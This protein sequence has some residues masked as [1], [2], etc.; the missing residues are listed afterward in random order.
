MYNT[1]IL[2]LSISAFIYFRGKVEGESL[3][4]VKVWRKKEERRKRKENEV[5]SIEESKIIRI[6]RPIVFLQKGK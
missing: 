1:F 2:N 6:F 3:V 5:K 4:N